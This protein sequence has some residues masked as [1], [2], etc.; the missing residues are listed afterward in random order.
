M[1]FTSY[2]AQYLDRPVVR[3]GD[4][5]R[6]QCFVHSD[7][8]ESKHWSCTGYPDGHI[9]CFACRWRG[10]II[11]LA[12]RKEHGTF[13][14]SGKKA[15]DERLRQSYAKYL[16]DP[17]F[18]SLA[19]DSVQEDRPRQQFSLLQ[20]QYLQG[21][22]E[23]MRRDFLRDD[24]ARA[25]TSRRGCPSLTCFGVARG[26]QM[27]ELRALARD[28]GDVSLIDTVGVASK[29]YPRSMYYILRDSLV[30]FNK[31]RDG[32]ISY[33][34]ARPFGEKIARFYVPPKIDKVPIRYIIDD[35]QP[36]IG[37]E[38]FYTIAWLAERG[39]N[40]IA[41]LGQ[42][43]R[44]LEARYYAPLNNGA[45]FIDINAPNDDGVRVGLD[46]AQKVYTKVVY[47]GWNCKMFYP[48]K[49]M[50]Q[51]DEWACSIGWSRAASYVRRRLS[52]EFSASGK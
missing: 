25:Y 43:D 24:E 41:F 4:K 16:R 20:K 8:E 37:A 34:Q 17:L 23:V 40:T 36:S 11:D 6:W 33:Y 22:Y 30:V 48:G 29:K 50:C 18:K 46:I 35:S 51:A 52:A 12:V 32:T 3:V 38:G 31:E 21:M 7:G 47:S 28:L 15:N 2:Y 19:N 14:P 9:F 42:S 44:S 13:L 39:F 10:S 1:D 45:Y 5:V 26:H 49:G 27:A